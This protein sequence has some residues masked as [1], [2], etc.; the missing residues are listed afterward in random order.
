[1]LDLGGKDGEIGNEDGASSKGTPSPKGAT[2][3]FDYRKLTIPS[4]NFVSVPSGRAPQFDGTHY[5]AWKHKMKL[6]LISLHPSIW[7]VVCTGI[8]VPHEDMELTSEKEQLIHRNAQAS[9]AILSALSPEEFDKGSPA[10]REAKIELL[11]GRLGRFV[12][13]DNETPQ[14]MY[15]RM[16]IL[17]NKIKGLGSEDMTNHFVV[18]RLLRA[19]GP[20]NPTLV[21]MIQERKDFKRLTPSDILGRIVSHK[22]QEE[23]AREVRQMVKNAAMIKNQ[24]VALKAKQEEESSGEES[25][26]EE[27]AFI[28]KRF[29][30]FLRKS[31]YGKGRKVDDKGK[32]QSKRACFNCGEFGHFI[33]DCPKSNEA[34][35][36][37]GKKKLERAHVAE[38]H[39]AEVWYSGDEE[40]PE[41]KPKP[42]SKDKVEGE[43]GVAT[44]T[45][46]S[47][48]S[49][50]ERLFN[51]LSDDD[52]DSYHYSCFMAQGRKVMTQKP[53]HTSLD[54]ESSDEE[55][56]NE[57][58][59]VL[60]SFSKP[61]MQH[62]AK[63]MRAL[64][65]T[66]QL[67]V[68]Q[69]ELLILEKKR[70]LALEESLAKESAKNKQLANELNFANGS[71]ASLRDVNETLQEKFACLDKSHKVQI[72]TLW[73]STSQPNVVSNSSNPSTSNGCARCYNIDLNSYATNIV[74]MQALKKENERLGTLVKYGC[75]KTYHSKDA[76]YK[77][78]TAHPNKDGHGLGF[79]GGSPVSKRVMV[80]GKEC[81]MFVR[82]GKAPQ[83]SEVTNLVSSQGPGTSGQTGQ[84]LRVG[85]SVSQKFPPGSSGQFARKFRANGRAQDITGSSEHNARRFWPDGLYYDSYVIFKN[86]EGK[87]VAYFN[88]NYNDEY[89][90]CVWVPKALAYSSGG[91]SWVVDS[92]CTNHMTGERSMFTSLDEENGTRENIVFGDDGKGKLGYN[93]LFT[94]EDVTVFRRD[95][96]SVAF[97]GKLKGDLYL[98]DF[99]VDRVNPEACLIAKSSMGWLWHRRLA[100]VGM[101]NLAT[102]LKGE[103]ILR[104]T[105][106]TFEKDRVCSACQAGKQVGNPHPI[107]NIMTT[108]RPLELLHMDLFG[109]MVYISIGGNKY[110]FFIVD[111]FSRFTWVYFLHD[112]SEAQDVFKRFAKQAQNLYDLT[113]KRVRSDNGGEFKNTQVEEFLDEVGIKH[114]FSAPYD[115]PQNGIVERKN[116]TLIEAARSML[117][118]YKTSDIFWAEA[119]STACHAINRLYL[120]KILKKTSYELLSGKK[121]NVS[122]F[123]V[124]GS[125]CFI[126]SKRPRSSKFSPK[127]DEGFLLGYESNAHAY[128]VFNKT[129]GIVEVTRDVTFDESNG[130][131]GEQVVVHVVSDVDPSQAIGTKAIGDIRPV[132]TQDDQE[133][134]DQPSSST[135]NSPKLSQVSVD[136]EVPGPDGRNLRTSPGQEVPGPS[137]RKFRAE[138]SQGVPMAQVDG[139]DAEGTVEHPDQA[140]VPSVHHPRIHHTVQRDHPVD[141]ILGDIRK[142]VT[143]RS[144]VAS[145]CQH[146]SFVSSLEST[147][148]ED[149]LG[150][151]DWVMAMLFQMDVKSAFLNGPISELVFVEQPPGFE[152]PKLPNHVYKLHKA[153]YGLKQAPRAWYEC[154]RDFLLK[155]GFE[156]GKADTTLF[157]K[158]FK[159]DLFICQIYVDDIIFGSTNASFC[160]EFSSIMTK[161]FEMSMMGELTFFLGLQVK[162]AQEGTFISQTKYVKDILKKFGMEDAKPIKT[163][164]PTNGHL[165]LDDNGKC[166]DQKDV[167]GDESPPIRF[168]RGR[169]GKEKVVEGGSG[170]GTRTSPRF[171]RQTSNRPVQ[172]RDVDSGQGSDAPSSRG[173]GRGGGRSSGAGRASHDFP[174]GS[175]ENLVRL[176]KTIGFDTTPMH[177][178][179][180]PKSNYLH[181][182]AK[183]RRGR[184]IDP[185]TQPEESQDPR[186]R[187][188][189]Q[190]DW[191]NSVIM[192]RDNLVVEMKWI[193]WTY[194]RKKNNE[195]F[196]QAMQVCHNKNLGDILA[197]EYDWNEEVI[198]QFYATAFFGSTRKGTPYVKWM[199]EGV[200]HKISIA[201]FAEILGLEDEDLNRPNIHSEAPLPLI[202]TKFMY[203]KN[204]PRTC[205][206][207][208]HGLHPNYKVLYSIFRW[209]LLPKVGDATALPSKHAHLLSRMRYNQPPFSVKLIWYE[210]ANTI[211]EPKRGCIYAPFIMKMIESV[212]GVFYIKD[213]RHNPFRPRVPPSSSSVAP[214]SIP[215]TSAGPSS[216]APPPSSS[217]SPIK[218]ALQAIFCMCAKT[219]KKVKKIERRQKEDRREAGK[220][221]S[222]DSED[223]VYV[224]PFEAYEAARNVAG[225]GPSTY[226]N[227]ESSQSDDDDDDDDDE[228]DIDAAAEYVP[229]DVEE[230][231]DTAAQSDESHLSGD[232]EIV[233]SDGD[234]DE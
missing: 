97:K 119:V 121:P 143:T 132:E 149:A 34:K 23:E 176:Y 160:E 37:G 222:D 198:A 81:L 90:T 105:N 171:R 126:L 115:P 177:H 218:K 108:T 4:H 38:A 77:T 150:D 139:I 118:E 89:R 60:K 196:N 71:L 136:P 16:M 64:D 20:R 221:V 233:P 127:V 28:V 3:P 55:S 182:L 13:D 17:V 91:S 157:T 226:F 220:E 58:D 2:I 93:C 41:V 156:I 120:H 204:A 179:G 210:I 9:N 197:L 62:L 232:T 92:G 164:M 117:D 229:T 106:V 75:M 159:S 22:M 21:S 14:E 42:K 188:L 7:K 100:H 141:N 155:N 123:R 133:D 148:V 193:D 19:F 183:C 24:E 103:H 33:A 52:D 51:N 122:Y 206:G 45:F 53:S 49:S 166:V 152:D 225:E 202:K 131:Q 153:L 129:S 140:Q 135:S 181:Q 95:D 59:D 199:T 144:R 161:R 76:L 187:T 189:T 36:K 61:A 201:Q 66:E 1:M 203:T 44:V 96:S 86:S 57:L 125:K 223:E 74:A 228:D 56:D 12:M 68:R 32:R 101:R 185:E 162:Q 107:K 40:D 215:S 195:V 104:L 30:H 48:S 35:A 29:K 138:D 231:V 98:V 85:V 112:K 227:E 65:S 173:R 213:G 15:D 8:D 50:K 224:D 80:N 83:A 168:P 46:K 25:E 158:K 72:D 217:S 54:V 27:M 82:E 178:I 84:N 111:D 208:T 190:L 47:S 134:R 207:P 63:L 18:K 169:L 94:D 31:G 114:E 230:A 191:Y 110:D 234:G 43:G 209:S 124:F 146:Y 26:D 167:S 154:L 67:L 194:M 39:M 113:I 142:G 163:P 130:F 211:L 109:P 212:T 184:L 78:I 116:R 102:L 205:M 137:A 151:P 145:F 170:S 79:S 87:V 128:R 175:R 69:E 216:S 165:D 186:F 200:R 88:G 6:H 172:I 219:A 99:D 147:R 10:V 70:N 11:E 73:N 5:A 192:A 174:V 214:R 180:R